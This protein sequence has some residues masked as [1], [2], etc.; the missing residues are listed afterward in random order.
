MRALHKKA[1]P[2][3]CHPRAKAQF[4]GLARHARILPDV[5]LLRVSS[6]QLR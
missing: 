3:E 2:A 1:K 6:E 4:A 5:N